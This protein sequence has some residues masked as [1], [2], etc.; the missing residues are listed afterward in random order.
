MTSTLKNVKNTKFTSAPTN[1]LEKWLSKTGNIRF[2]SSRDNN[3][4]KIVTRRRQP[5]TDADAKA[6]EIQTKKQ[7][8]SFHLWLVN[9]IMHTRKSKYILN[10]KMFSTELLINIRA[11]FGQQKSQ[12]QCGIVL[13][14]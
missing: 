9:I 11:F 10:T 1:I 4:E 5:V 8:V 7:N 12:I 3:A 2:V 14:V 6:N 13:N